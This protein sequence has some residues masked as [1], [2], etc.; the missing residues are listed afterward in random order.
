[1]IWWQYIC[2]FFVGLIS[3]IL[4]VGI[5]IATGFGIYFLLKW[6]AH[7]LGLKGISD[8]IGYLF[9]GIFALYSVGFIF[10]MFFDFGVII[11]TKI[12]WCGL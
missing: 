10:S 2:A 12:G 6:I 3:I 7:K 5:P 11:C 4:L 9:L 1:M 8:L